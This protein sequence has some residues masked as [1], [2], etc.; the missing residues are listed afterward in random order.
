MRIVRIERR[1]LPVPVPDLLSKEE[2]AA[3]SGIHPELVEHLV[4][5]GLLDP[6]R[7]RPALFRRETTLRVQRIL[8]LRRD[9]NASYNAVGLILD[10]LDRIEELERELER[11]P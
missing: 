8:R 7:R 10:L 11:R 2:V 4:A 9:F 6:V 1:A 3:R 5:L